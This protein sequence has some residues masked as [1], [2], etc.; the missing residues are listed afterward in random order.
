MIVFVESTDPNII[1]KRVTLTDE[2][3][4]GAGIEVHAAIVNHIK[5]M[6]Q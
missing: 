1:P 4:S 3:K 6:V 2:V 5:V